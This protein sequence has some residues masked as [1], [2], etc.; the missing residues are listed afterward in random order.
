MKRKTGTK[1]RI[2]I[3]KLKGGAEGIGWDRPFE[4][5]ALGRRMIHYVPRLRWQPGSDPAPVLSPLIVRLEARQLTGSRGS[6]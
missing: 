3:G 4:G 5:S 2:K 1:T 6:S